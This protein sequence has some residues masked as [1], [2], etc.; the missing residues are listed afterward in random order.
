MQVKY[1]HYHQ[2]QQNHNYED[3]GKYRLTHD[4]SHTQYYVLANGIRGNYLIANVLSRDENPILVG[5]FYPNNKFTN[6]AVLVS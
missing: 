1:I 4:L 2:N 6:G 5:L 3:V